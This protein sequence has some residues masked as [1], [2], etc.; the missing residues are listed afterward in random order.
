M[1][2]PALQVCILYS[3]KFNSKVVYEA[4]DCFSLA[5]KRI[6]R[7]KSIKEFVFKLDQAEGFQIGEKLIQSFSK[8]V[9]INDEDLNY[10]S[11][12]TSSTSLES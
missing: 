2:L 7:I 6:S 10:L 5:A 9:F 3:K 1:I 8:S 12:G 4:C 11:K